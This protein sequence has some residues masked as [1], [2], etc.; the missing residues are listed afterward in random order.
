MDIR[1]LVPAI[2]AVGLF[3]YAQA[4][5]TPATEIPHRAPFQTAVA[6]AGPVGR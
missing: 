5:L 1:K 3:L 2:A 6:Q 4:T